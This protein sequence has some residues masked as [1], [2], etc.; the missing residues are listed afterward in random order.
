[1]S[2]FGMACMVIGLYYAIKYDV[3]RNAEDIKTVENKVESAEKTYLSRFTTID[4]RFTKISDK[5]IERAREIANNRERLASIEALLTSNT[6]QLD[7][8]VSILED[9]NRESRNRNGNGNK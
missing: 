7:H 8:I 1:M 5:D 2:F 3:Q 4:Q 6:R 9:L